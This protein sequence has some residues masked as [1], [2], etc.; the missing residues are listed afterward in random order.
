MDKGKIKF[1]TEKA[2]KQSFL[3]MKN[4]ISSVINSGSVDYDT[5]SKD[6]HYLVNAILAA[7]LINEGKNKHHPKDGFEEE[8]QNIQCFV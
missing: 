8:V 7:I 2:L 1:L 6:S 3:S 4:Q 5:E